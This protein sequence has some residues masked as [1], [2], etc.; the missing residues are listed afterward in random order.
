MRILIFGLV[1]SIV[2]SQPNADCSTMKCGTGQL[3]EMKKDVLFFFFS[4]I[5]HFLLWYQSHVL[6]I[7]QQ[8]Y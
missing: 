1:A 5:F 8:V 6:K 3:C 4:Q 7:T 2:H